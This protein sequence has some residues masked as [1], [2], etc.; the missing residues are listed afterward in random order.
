MKF[1]V[2]NKTEKNFSLVYLEE[3]HSF[4]IEPD[5]ELAYGSISVNDLQLELDNEERIIYVHGYTPLFKYK[6]IDN[7]PRLYETKDL[8]AILDDEPDPDEFP[9]NPTY[10]LVK[11]SN[12]PYSI[13]WDIYINKKMGWVCVGDPTIE[14][15]RLIEFAPD[16]VAALDK[17]NEMVAIWLHPRELPSHVYTKKE[18]GE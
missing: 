9:G 13:E 14:G 18:D 15:K 2:K 11:N 16:C 17:E 6:E 8:I 4:F 10:S 3:E 5:I 1:F 12:W 7:F